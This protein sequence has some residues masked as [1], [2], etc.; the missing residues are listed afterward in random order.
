VKTIPARAQDGGE[1][2]K[3]WPRDGR[4][5][6][7]ADLTEMVASIGEN[8][9]CAAP[10]PVG[11]SRVVALMCIITLRKKTGQIGLMVG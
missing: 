11:Q 2:E 9:S 1:L 4:V 7:P 6:V 5:S 8:M 10:K 3:G